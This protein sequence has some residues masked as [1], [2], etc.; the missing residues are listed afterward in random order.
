VFGLCGHSLL[1][2]REAGSIHA[3]GMGPREMLRVVMRAYDGSQRTREDFAWQSIIYQTLKAS[4]GAAQCGSRACSALQSNAKYPG[5]SKQRMNSIFFR[6][7]AAPYA[8]P[9]VSVLNRQGAQDNRA[10]L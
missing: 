7:L 10:S 1:A 5:P 3:I 6:G 9:S 2:P 4:A 8:P